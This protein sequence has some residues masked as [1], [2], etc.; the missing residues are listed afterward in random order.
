M[1]GETMKIKIMCSSE[2]GTYWRRIEL[3]AF[4]MQ[5]WHHGYCCRWHAV[6]T[7]WNTATCR[8]N[9]MFSRSSRVCINYMG[10]RRWL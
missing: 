3:A 10:R 7:T 4:G 5:T 1:H 2:V 8:S 9:Q 6:C